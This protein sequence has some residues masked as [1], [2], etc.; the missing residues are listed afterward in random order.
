MNR[1]ASVA[2]VGLRFIDRVMGASESSND[3]NPGAM[4]AKM[5][6][7]N[8][9]EE[10]E[11][12]FGRV[13]RQ[14]D[15]GGAF[16]FNRA[17]NQRSQVVVQRR[18]V[19]PVSFAA[20]CD[21]PHSQ[22]YLVKRH[23][24]FGEAAALAHGNQPTVAHPFVSGRK[25]LLNV[26]LLVGRDLGFP[27]RGCSSQSQPHRRICRHV[28]TADSLL[29]DRRKNFQLGERGVV[30]SGLHQLFRR[31]RPKSRILG[32]KLICDLCRCDHV[33][34]RKKGADCGPARLIPNERQL[35]CVFLI[36]KFRNPSVET[37]ALRL[38]RERVF[39]HSALGDELS[40][41][42]ARA[43]GGSADAGGLATPRAVGLLKANPVIRA[44]FANIMRR[45]P[46]SMV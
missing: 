6:E 10:T 5:F 40:N 38:L 2:N 20:K 41:F 28:A 44:S 11:P 34:M 16:L 8:L 23:G 33:T 43:V 13:F 1:V 37:M 36:E 14:N 35:V 24:G 30:R 4:E 7:A 27:L 25:R 29:H 12:R 22:I 31:M 9:P 45:H 21:R 32:A 18:T 19:Q 26:R 15:K 39:V 42:S 3:G 46:C 17:F